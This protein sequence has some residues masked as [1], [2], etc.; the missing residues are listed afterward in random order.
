MTGRVVI[1]A[2]THKTGSTSLQR[3]CAD[4]R[5][6]LARQGVIYPN[7]RRWLHKGRVAAHHGLAAALVDGHSREVASLVARERERGTVLLSS[8]SIWRHVSGSHSWE[9]LPAGSYWPA[10]SAYLDALACAVP[11]AEILVLLRRP[12]RLAE[13][14]YAERILYHHRRPSFHEWIEANPLLDYDGQV[15]ALRCAF[16]TVTV[17]RYRVGQA[18]ADVLAQVGARPLPE[19]LI[20]P[21]PD[22]RI[23]EWL[24]CSPGRNLAHRRAFAV[25]ERAAA[26]FDE[27]GSHWRSTA[28]RDQFLARFTGEFG[29]GFFSA[30]DAAGPSPSTATFDLIEGEFQ[31]WRA[32]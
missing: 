17:L 14:G 18:V 28:E 32:R 9:R 2:G 13:S 3:A 24:R 21:S 12:D 27:R 6:T 15:A 25:S 26:L 23:I 16:E 20:R 19:R 31:Q 1:H 29:A 8:E 22:P 4:N 11:G 30:P 7:E 10:R 5:S